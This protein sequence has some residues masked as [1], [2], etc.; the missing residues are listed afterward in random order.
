M[1]QPLEEDKLLVEALIHGDAN[2]FKRLYDKHHGNLY[3]YALKFVKSEELAKEIVHDVFLKIWEKRATL[4]SELSF[5]GF[6]L[7]VCK[8]YTLN[9]LVKLA[10]ENAFKKEIA[11]HITYSHNETENDILYADYE[12]FALA[13]INLLPPQRQAI[14]KMCRIEG[15]SY[16]EAAESFGISKGTVRDHMLKAGR[17][18]KEYLTTHT[19]LTFKLLIFYSCLQ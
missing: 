3:R 6:L 15:K 13:A 19:N 18:I 1:M 5:I 11:R 12:K 9:V 8:N 10:R 17:S 16:D 14:Y 4:N 2:S 7:K